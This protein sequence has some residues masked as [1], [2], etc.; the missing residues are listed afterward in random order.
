MTVEDAPGDHAVFRVRKRVS[1]SIK[2]LLLLMLLLV[3]VGSNV[4]VGVIGYIN[5]TE[6]LTNAAVRA[7]HRS[8]RLPCSR[9]RQPLR[10]DRELAAAGEPRQRRGGCRGRLR[11]RRRR[12][13]ERGHRG[14]CRGCRRTRG[15]VGAADARAGGANSRPTS[16]MTSAR[17]STRRPGEQADAS[18]FIPA[19]AAARY[20]LYHYVVKGGDDPSAVDDAGD[21]S[22]WTAA[23]AEFH[24]YLRRLATLS[25]Y[26]DLVLVSAP[27]RSCTRSG[28]M[29]TSGPT[30][31]R[32]RTA[33]PRWRAPSRPRWPAV[34]LD[35]VTFAD[36]DEYAP[37]FD[38]PTAWAVAPLASDDAIV[39][40]IAVR[41]A[42]RPHRRGHDRRR[43]LGGERSRATPARPTSSASDHR[44]ARCRATS[45]RTPRATRARGRRRRWLAR[46]RRRAGGRDRARP[47]SCSR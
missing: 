34:G 36:F 21:G 17:H 19:S 14:R 38:D 25:G 23:H 16:R 18:S 10:H 33:T 30:W 29:S 28:R 15:L 6:S 32:A 47:C 9:D 44:C 39:G 35:S 12:S 42:G 26:P 43:Q 11:E 3:S 1:L 20:L 5:G 31:S 27:V 4:V 41:L 37:A 8:A 45:S 24:D 40:A 13:R 46:R 2:S 22:A 7:S